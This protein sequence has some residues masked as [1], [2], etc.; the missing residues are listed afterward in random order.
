LPKKP[1]T[2]AEQHFRELVEAIGSAMLPYG[3]RRRGNTFARASSE[4]WMMFVLVKSAWSSADSKDVFVEIGVAPK[5]WLLFNDSPE[6]VAPPFRNCLWQGRLGFLTP[7]P[8]RQKW[9]IDG[10][11]SIHAVLDALLT[12]LTT[13]AL[14]YLD[15]CATEQGLL[16]AYQKTFGAKSFSWIMLRLKFLILADGGDTDELRN[17]IADYSNIRQPELASPFLH[18]LAR[19]YPAISD[20][21]KLDHAS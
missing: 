14:P 17:M 15:T 1:I 4:C 13:S 11:D 9:T 18:Q 2:A 10:A 16:E 7:E 5:R 6:A 20:S 8:G 3:Y 19:R 21:I 12:A